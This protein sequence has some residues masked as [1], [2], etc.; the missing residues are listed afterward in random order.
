MFIFL[1]VIIIRRSSKINNCL[2]NYIGVSKTKYNTYY[3]YINKDNKRQYLGCFE[4]PEEAAKIR[5][6]KAIEIYGDYAKLNFKI[7]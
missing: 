4:T 2:T 1:F 5:D 6:A 3:A 7:P